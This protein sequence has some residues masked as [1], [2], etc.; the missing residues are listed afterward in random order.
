MCFV[1]VLFLMVLGT[2][3][4]L[5]FMLGKHFTTELITLAPGGRLGPPA[6]TSSRVSNPDVIQNSEAEPC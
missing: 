4:E 6:Q 3:P 5:L 1:V 2:E